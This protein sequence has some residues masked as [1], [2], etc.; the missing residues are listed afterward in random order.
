MFILVSIAYQ[1][2]FN[3]LPFFL[4]PSR[5]NILSILPLPFF[6]IVHI[7]GTGIFESQAKDLF[8]V[9]QSSID[10]YTLILLVGCIVT[11]PTF[12]AGFYIKSE[13]IPLIRKLAFF[14]KPRS[15][16][17]LKG[18]IITVLALLSAILF[19][20]AYIKIGFAPLLTE[21]PEVARFFADKYEEAYRPYAGIFRLSLILSRVFIFILLVRILNKFRFL[22]IALVL[23]L[24]FLLALSARRGLIFSSLIL[25]IL[26]YFSCKRKLLFWPVVSLYTV[27]TGLG[28]AIF[29]LASLLLSTSTDADV[30]NFFSI[31]ISGLPD[32][33]DSL[34]FIDNWLVHGWHPTDGLSI[35]GGL[36][37]DQFPY[38]PSIIS[39]LVLGSKA[40]A[41][42]GGFRLDLAT[43]GY[44]A[45]SWPGI[46]LFSALYGYLGGAM[47]QVYKTVVSQVENLQ[48]FLIWTFLFQELF[49]LTT[50][51]FNM[52]IDYLIELVIVAFIF[53]STRIKVKV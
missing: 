41:A 38:N 11:L 12:L 27:C 44:I 49:G 19:T 1:S 39:K 21:K 53:L 52:K 22:D 30:G 14:L 48:E 35:I 7:I 15:S 8:N 31:L 5:R 3:L 16:E 4:W 42:T 28:S 23:V 20:Y 43:L 45:F 29:T 34:W 32:V 37:P 17:F 9:T 24:T 18:N 26:G 36:F 10:E 2:I 50:F 46:V 25:V 33:R 47:L 51:I 6:L 40:N 13:A